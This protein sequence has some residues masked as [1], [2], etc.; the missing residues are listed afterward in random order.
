ML[1]GL[2]FLQ[3]LAGAGGL[4]ISRAVVRD[5]HSGAAAV[6]LFSSL[7]LVTGLAPILAPLVGGQLLEDHVVARDLRLAGGPVGADRRAR[8]G[9][10]ARDA[11]GGAPQPQRA[12][13]YA[14]DDARAAA[15][16]LVRRLRAGGRARVRRAVRLHRGLV[17]RAAGDLRRVAAALQPPVRDERPR[18]DRGSQVN[19][20]LVGRFGPRGCC[21]RGWRVDRERAHAAGGGLDRRAS[22]C[23]PC[24]SPM[25]VI[26]SSLAFVLPNSTALALAD[27]GEVAGTASALLGVIQ[28]LDRRDRGAAG[29]RGRDRQR[30][31][32]GRS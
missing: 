1:I 11:A 9:R 5:L 14:A 26:V 31:A 25:F 12:A 3:G 22:G 29:R 7:M 15:R 17:V 6:R 23:G 24:W 19:A 28:F 10:P 27:H 2:R 32:D 8:R 30:G 21:A 13:A 20:R 4:V 16:P 18:A